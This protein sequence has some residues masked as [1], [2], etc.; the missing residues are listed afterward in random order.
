VL[1]GGII[2]GTIGGTFGIMHVLFVCRTYPDEI[3][4]EVHPKSA[5]HTKHPTLQ[6]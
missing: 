6:K 4:Q 2:G 3:L 5:T 1:F